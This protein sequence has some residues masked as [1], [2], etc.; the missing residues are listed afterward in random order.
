M[1]HRVTDPGAGLGPVVVKLGG[2]ALNEPRQQARLFAALVAIHQAHPAG[3][4]VVHGGGSAVDRHLAR[5]GATSLRR[6]GIRITP[7]DLIDEIVA[8]LAGAVN[9]RLVGAL[10]RQGA[11]AVGLCLGDGRAVRTV[12]TTRYAFDA[13]RVGE[14]AG[15][16]AELPGL[17]LA[18]GYIPVVC[19]IGLDDDGAAL[20]VNAD[21]AAA[22]VAR[23]V[24]ASG[25]LFLT[26]VPGVLDERGEVVGS[27]GAGSIEQWIAEGRITG[28]MI[29]K[30][31]SAASAATAAAVP[32]TIASWKDP[33][34]LPG[35]ARGER[36][37]TRIVPEPADAP[38]PAV[39]VRQLPAS[40]GRRA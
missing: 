4:V 36:A 28:G 21:D 23:L 7:P 17:L 8:V 31:R 9:K 32:V 12:R 40:C 14:V 26:D 1:P 6:E 34:R 2:A 19:S 25:L 10:Q 30:V 27:L 38:A 13:G 35:L 39:P 24:R 15:G 18:A 11:R 5:I 29:A 16:D 3:L 37:G 22:G 33:A 20:N